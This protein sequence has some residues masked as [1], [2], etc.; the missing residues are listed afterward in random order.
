ML[1]PWRVLVGPLFLSGIGGLAG[2]LLF[3]VYHTQALIRC[4]DSFEDKA[5][6]G[7]CIREIKSLV[8]NDLL[9]QFFAKI[10]EY[11]TPPGHTRD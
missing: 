6:V 2:A 9:S 1:S 10:K 7:R 3:P 8:P 4:A 11:S 5:L